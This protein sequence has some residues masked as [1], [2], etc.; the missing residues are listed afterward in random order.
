MSAMNEVAMMTN[1]EPTDLAALPQD[2]QIDIARKYCDVHPLDHY[3]DAVVVLFK[4]LRVAMPKT[5]P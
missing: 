5:N 4:A 2:Q 1:I 3:E